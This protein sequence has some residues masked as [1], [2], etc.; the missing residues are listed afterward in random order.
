MTLLEH[1]A[2]ARTMGPLTRVAVLVEDAGT[3]RDRLSSTLQQHGFQVHSFS[4]GFAA[5]EAVDRLQPDLVTVDTTLAGIDGF[6]VVRRIRSFHAGSIVI[7]SDMTEETAAV[8]AF[9]SGADDYVVRPWRPFEL[10]ARLDAILRRTLGAAEV[11]PPTESDWLVVDGLRLHPA[12]R[13]AELAGRRIDL[14]RSEFDLLLALVRN[15][16]V[17]LEKSW[18]VLLLRRQ[19]GGNG[20]HV[21][22]HD[23]HAVEVHVMNLR[24]KL[25]GTA[26]RCRWIETVRGIGY[27]FAPAKL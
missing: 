2:P 12:S 26:R 6:E 3:A 13:R 23:L 17:V 25:G 15:P 8:E 27:R 10:R 1:P 9:R 14:T 7:L 5:V 18:I 21:N 11:L 16:D 22:A 4:D 19:N 20:D 24:R